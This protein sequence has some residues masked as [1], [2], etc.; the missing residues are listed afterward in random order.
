MEA[1]TT[2]HRDVRCAVL[3]DRHSA[4]SDGV[5]GLLETCFEVVVMVSD[6]LSLF[7]AVGRMGVDLAVVDLSLTRGNGFEL[8]SRLHGKFPD[9]KLI[10]VSVHE[11]PSVARG[12]LRA[13][14]DQFV[15]KRFLST[16]LIPAV[17]AALA[18]P[19]PEQ[20]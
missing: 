8:I 15:P 16:R 3:A 7:E 9:V 14:A 12:A 19:H 1:A 4:V 17:D 6:E 2:D 18:E 5:R 20:P 13:G 10:A 11:E